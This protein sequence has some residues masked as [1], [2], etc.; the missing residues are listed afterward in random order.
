MLFADS[1]YSDL[2]R[3][4]LLEQHKFAELF[5]VP[6]KSVQFNGGRLR[7]RINLFCPPTTPNW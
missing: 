1:A 3:A 4:G 7:L 6:A 2:A 5:G